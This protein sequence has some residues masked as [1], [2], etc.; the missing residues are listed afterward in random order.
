MIKTSCP[1]CALE[2]QGN[3]EIEGKF[4]FRIT[5]ETS[6]PQSWCRRCRSGK[7]IEEIQETD[8]REIEKTKNSIQSYV[9]RLEDIETLRNLFIKPDGLNYNYKSEDI[10]TDEWSKESQKVIEEFNAEIKQI[11]EKTNIEVIYVNISTNDEKD[12]KKIAKEIFKRRAGYCLIIT[13]NS[14]DQK[15]WLFTGSIDSGNSA[16]NILLETT[17]GEVSADLV[18]WLIKIK[19]TDD[20]TLTTLISKINSS[21]DDY[22]ID[23]QDKLGEN[24]F[25]AFEILI[26]EVVFNKENK[27]EFTDE[28]LK[29]IN[30]P[31]FT[32]LYRL[33]FILYAESRDIFDPNNSKYYEDYSLKKI[34]HTLMRKYEKDSESIKLKKYEL[35]D[36]LQN[37]FLLIEN[38][39]KYL[40]I[41]E[42]EINMPAYNGSLFNSEKNPLLTRWKFDND[43][44]IK[45]IHSLTRIQDK[46]KNY[47]FVNYAAIEIS[48]IGTIYEKL[49]EFHPEK[50]GNR[51]EI[52]THEGKRETE[53][54][55]YT[56]KFI[57]D[58]IVENALGPLV[59]N[60]VNNTKNLRDQVEKILQLKILDPAMGSGH[61]LVGAAEYLGKRIIQI[62][63]NDSEQNFIER[64]RD[65]VRRCLYGVD[66]NP[67]AVELAK[68]SLWLD[69]LST[70]HALSFLATHLKNGDTLLSSWRKEIFD[71]QT[72]FGEDPSKSYFRDFVKQYS[73]FETID[74]HRASTVRSKIE[75]EEETRK[76]GSPYDH[77]KYLFD[78][79]LSKYYGNEIKDW[80]E[81]RTKIGTSEF[82]KIVK[83]IDWSLNRHFS[84]D[85]H[86]FHWELEFPQVFVD[87]EGKK[88]TNPGFDVIIGNPPYGVK[89]EGSFYDTFKLGS[90]ESYGFFMN[91][92]IEILKND[93]IMSMVVSDTW[94][95]IKTH[96]PL[97]KIILNTCKI[98][99]LIKLSRYAFKTHGRNI[100]A[101]TIICEFQK[102]HAN[103]K[104]HY[105]YYD[106]WQIHPLHEKEFFNNLINHANYVHEKNEWPFEV[107]RTMRYKINQESIS[108]FDLLPIYEGDEEIFQL[109]DK[110]AS[111]E[112]IEV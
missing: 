101:F 98:N 41:D 26:N 27:L 75:E 9:N 7:T 104:D 77:L 94:R 10:P 112:Y 65:V 81:L 64:K 87:A 25:N 1:R 3:E 2:A 39:S 67:L 12:W 56:P 46:E 57:V 33:V 32:L 24:V 52:F 63:N 35:W 40:R 108:K 43:S 20:E 14:N 72:Y 53:G 84:K 21:F 51:I 8:K 62:D 88:L 71:A 93:G 61:F 85:T 80:R 59:D 103:N 69:T 50:R 78:V 30:D 38:G 23:M 22:A 100:D 110:N 13:H 107:T 34:T 16:K 105:F 90:K 37:L 91:K 73:A 19:A 18:A 28:N 97:R 5:H 42:K 106:F 66:I 44:L 102:K 99:R 45:A 4:G 92:A 86:F 83:G 109:F 36:R 70:E 17:D 74:D 58:N 111:K 49:L 89:Y 76:I 55:Y 29:R 15:K 6:I 82:D 54:T 47:S 48:H 96:L 95:T 68:M 31:L 79:Q 11:A 60:I